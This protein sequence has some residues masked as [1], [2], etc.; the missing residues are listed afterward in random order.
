MPYLCHPTQKLLENEAFLPKAFLPG[1]RLPSLNSLKEQGGSKRKSANGT[2]TLGYIRAVPVPT[3]ESVMKVYHK[4]FAEMYKQMAS[5]CERQERE[6]WQS[7]EVKHWATFVQLSLWTLSHNKDNHPVQ[8][9]AL[10]EYTD[11]FERARSQ[12]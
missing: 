12:L 7:H 9:K 8:L 1:T 10:A 4:E 6:G 11:N 3:R 5:L 2:R